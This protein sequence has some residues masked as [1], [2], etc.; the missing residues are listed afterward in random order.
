MHVLCTVDH[1]LISFTQ[2]F[3]SG[4][5]YGQI[6]GKKDPRYKGYDK[7]G[8]RHRRRLDSTEVDEYPINKITQSFRLTAL[9]TDTFG[10]EYF[11][12]IKVEVLI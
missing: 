9:E 1:Q 11:I 5:V 4:L 2:E 3:I 6:R 8:I 10:L 12:R 7:R